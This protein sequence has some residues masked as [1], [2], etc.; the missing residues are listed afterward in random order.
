MT[1]INTVMVERFYS[2]R[3]E[4]VAKATA[5]KELRTVKAACTRAVR[6]GYLRENPGRYVKPVRVPEKSL[7]VLAPAEV[8]DLLAACPSDRWRAF[9]AQAVVQ[10]LAGHASIMTTVR[11]YTHIMPDALR[12]ATDRLPFSEAIE[13]AAMLTNC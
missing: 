10:Q 12:A 8:G 1:D 4:A 13:S 11:H 9:V 3:L 5:N 7:R 6:R 2:A